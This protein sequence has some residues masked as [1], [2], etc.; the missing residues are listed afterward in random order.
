MV[1]LLDDSVR[2]KLVFQLEFTER[3]NKVGHL[4]LS[5]K[6]VSH[7]IAHVV[8]RYLLDLIAVGNWLLQ[9]NLDVA[10]IFILQLKVVSQEVL[11]RID[12]TILTH[13]K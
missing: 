2:V 8:H 12:G 5:H 11:Q 6:V 3:L 13:V 9:D 1:V 4:L 10:Q 7:L